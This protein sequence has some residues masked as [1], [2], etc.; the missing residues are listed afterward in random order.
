MDARCD[1][2]VCGGGGGIWMDVSPDGCDID[3]LR[4]ADL[5]FVR[6]LDLFL[7]G[8]GRLSGEFE[9]LVISIEGLRVF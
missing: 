7:A 9:K 8:S 2:W 3:C 6:N 4:S 5:E 1:D